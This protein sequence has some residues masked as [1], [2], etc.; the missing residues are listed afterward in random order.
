MIE[1]L[2]RSGALAALLSAICLTGTAQS[3]GP[4][5]TMAS[6]I[7]L[8]TFDPVLASPPTVDYLRPVYDTLVV[9]TGIDRYEPGLAKSF[10]YDGAKRE[11]RM[12][13]RAG[14]RF[15]DGQQ[16]D[17]AAVKANFDRGM[18]A[19]NTPWAD[20][21][22]NLAAVEVLAGNEVLL[23]LKAA[24]PTILESLSLMPGMMVSPAALAN[25]AAIAEAPVGTGPWTYDAARSVRG[26]RYTYARTPGYWN[27]A[28]Q[29]IDTLVIR[30][31]TD[32]AARVNALRAGQLDIAFIQQEQAEPLARLGF[33]VAAPN[34]IFQVL[35]IADAGGKTI[36]A[37]ADKRV[38]EAIGLALDRN[39]I[40]AVLYKGRGTASSN[41]YPAGTQGYSPALAARQ[42][43]DLNR[44]RALL[45]EA[46]HGSGFA[47]DVAVQ[48][49]NARFATAAAGELAKVGIKLNLTVLPDAGSWLTAYREHK[50]PIA[51]LAQRLTAPYGLWASFVAPNGRYNPYG[52][53]WP[54]MNAL[55]KQAADSSSTEEAKIGSLYARL[56]ERM[57]VGEAVL[58]PIVV[59]ELVCAMRQGITGDVRTYSGA[60][61]PDPRVLGVRS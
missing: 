41:F 17:A 26:E 47:V 13:L 55:A 29:R 35:Q 15:S 31:M 34:V 57:V 12:Q 50:A 52:L 54:A 43:Y 11:F 19:K 58:F 21:Y 40:L 5:V 24:D 44:A 4:T 9:K 48:S 30:Q 27:P 22:Q 53:D 49:N 3:A 32:A 59:A 51:L 45:A 6:G 16:F 42:P 25:P 7:G 39:A 38:R 10:H 20:V 28:V 14:V 33:Q 61:L 46:G 23:R 56:M 60:G 37:L 36:P 8:A 1:G 18:Q 2:R